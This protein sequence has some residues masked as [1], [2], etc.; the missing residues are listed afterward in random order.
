MFVQT[1]FFPVYK[2]VSLI[3]YNS[4]GN[5]KIYEA[6]R[7]EGAWLKPSFIKKIHLAFIKKE[8]EFDLCEGKYIER[9]FMKTLFMGKKVL[10]NFQREKKVISV[11]SKFLL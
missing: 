5:T 11:N 4:T 6:F 10:T 8:E 7:F 1:R 2:V 3:Q 9:T